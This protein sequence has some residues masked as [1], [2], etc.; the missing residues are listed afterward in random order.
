LAPPAGH[1]WE[2]A[3]AVSV[4]RYPLRESLTAASFAQ[5]PADRMLQPSIPENDV[6][7]ESMAD[8]RSCR[9]FEG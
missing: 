8:L 6:P 2:N 5:Q 3:A 4:L 7:K 9:L 1:D